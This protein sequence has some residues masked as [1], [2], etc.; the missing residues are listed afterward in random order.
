MELELREINVTLSKKQK[1]KIRNAFVN[2]EKIRL[3][4]TKDSLEECNTLLVPTRFFEEMDNEDG[5]DAVVGK[6]TEKEMRDEMLEDLKLFEDKYSSLT[7]EQLKSHVLDENLYKKFEKIKSFRDEI[8]EDLKLFEDKYPLIT[9]EKLKSSRYEM[10][11]HK[12]NREIWEYYGLFF[13]PAIDESMEKGIEFD[14]DY[15][16]LNDLAKDFV[17]DNIKKLFE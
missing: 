3:K 5:I 13:H 14:L 15:S 6:Q 17:K 9:L 2:S 16:L 10:L 7:W 12:I 8:L 11:E 1:Q 4:L